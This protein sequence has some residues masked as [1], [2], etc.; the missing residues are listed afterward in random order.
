MT[1]TL[2][3]GL[4]FAAF[5]A[6]ATALAQGGDP[7]DVNRVIDVKVPFF[8]PPSEVQGYNKIRMHMLPHRDE[9]NGT[10]TIEVRGTA[11]YPDDVVLVVGIRHAKVKEHFKKETKVIVKDRTFSCRFGPFK[12]VIPGG[13]LA[14]DAAFLM[15]SQSDKVKDVLL[16]ERWFHCNPPCSNDLASVGHIIWSNG[17]YEAQA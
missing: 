2:A 4:A 14:V 7:C 3:A 12:K 1:R 9:A 8:R 11:Y 17:G 16:K 6:P 10:L 15:G 13:G 5:L